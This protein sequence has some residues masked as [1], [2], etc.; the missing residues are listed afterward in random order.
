MRAIAL[1]FAISGCFT[2]SLPAPPPEM[3][4]PSL[5]IMERT[6]DTTVALV[7]NEGRSYCA[8]VF[9][10]GY[11]L[12]ANHCMPADE[13][14]PVGFQIRGNDRIYLALV[15]SHDEETDLAI[16]S[17]VDVLPPHVET[18]LAPEAPPVGEQVVVIGHPLGYRWYVTNGLSEGVRTNLQ[19]ER[20]FMFSAPTMYGNSGGPVFNQF[21]EVVAI[22][23]WLAW[24]RQDNTP[25]PHIAA[26]VP[27]EVLRAALSGAH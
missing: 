22:V 4:E 17:P 16:L 6:L 25:V 26:G 20:W 12:S 13:A 27:L 8:G 3:P 19:G 9:V 11:I 2:S 15:A 7:T 23:S 24:N 10:R 1:L 18:I 21:G 5:N 14:E